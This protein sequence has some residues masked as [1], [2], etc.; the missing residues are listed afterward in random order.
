MD[1]KSLIQTT[2]EDVKWATRKEDEMY[3]GEVLEERLSSALVD[4]GVDIETRL[5]FP[6]WYGANEDI[7]V[8]IVQAF[9]ESE[10]MSENEDPAISRIQ[11][12]LCD[13]LNE[14]PHIEETYPDF[15]VKAMSVL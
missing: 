1:Y 10:A 14:N 13:A 8:Q 11:N 15:W 9:I 7:V 2:I 6:A 4:G 3:G 5:G 12:D